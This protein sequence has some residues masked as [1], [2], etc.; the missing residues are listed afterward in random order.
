LRKARVLN[1]AKMSPTALTALTLLIAES[2]PGDKDKVVALVTML[3]S[4]R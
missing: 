2:A 1:T 4:Q 3:I